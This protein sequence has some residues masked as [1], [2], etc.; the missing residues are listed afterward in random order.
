MSYVRTPTHYLLLD[1]IRGVAAVVVMLYHYSTHSNFEM[2]L[3]APT[4]V[5]FFFALSGFVLTASYAQKIKV[6]RLTFVDYLKKRLIRLYP[7]FALGLLLG[8]ASLLGLY[9]KGLTNDL[10]LRD[11]A[12][13]AATN[14]F[15]IPYLN[16]SSVHLFARD[17]ASAGA[18]FPANGPAWS[19]FYEMVASVI[20]Y[21]LVSLDR[22]LLVKVSCAS[23][24]F[25]LG[26]AFLRGF[27]H[28]NFVLEGEAGWASTNI[29]GGFPRVMWGFCVGVLCYQFVTIGRE[30]ATRF[31]A[32][33]YLS[34]RP[35]W[36]LFACGALFLVPVQLSGLTFFLTVV[37]ACPILLVAGAES[38]I[39]SRQLELAAKAL[40]ALSYPIYCLHVPIGNAVALVLRGG[41]DT[42]LPDWR[43]VVLATVLTTVLSA[44]LLK[45]VDEPIRAALTRRYS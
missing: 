8:T 19:L 28:Y 31:V 33:T 32:L 29:F 10:S 44:V 23:L 1:G 22:S 27:E 11:I 40:G 24:F 16:N 35:L 42:S 6:G 2:F 13:A 45:L 9:F 5:D 26:G 37:C 15:F 3:N 18:I 20:F 14:A 4:A 21:C 12:S 39:H 25:L 7:M 43:F 17:V 36:I 41:G 30:R 38:V 34:G